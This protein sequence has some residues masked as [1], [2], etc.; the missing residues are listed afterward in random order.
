[1][2]VLKFQIQVYAP[3]VSGILS[4][5]CSSIRP[6]ILSLHAQ[7]ARYD[8][9]H[10]IDYSHFFSWMVISECVVLIVVPLLDRGGGA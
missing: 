5:N 10:H 8:I 4:N 3:S 9:N 7:I 6:F 2:D 1:M